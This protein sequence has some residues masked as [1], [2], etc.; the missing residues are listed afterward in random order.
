[1]YG[2]YLRQNQCDNDPAAGLRQF[3]GWEE[4]GEGSFGEDVRIVLVSAEFSKEIT[5]SVLWLNN[6]S[7]D[8]RCVRL[9]PH[10]LDGRLILDVQ[11]VI[12][13]PEAADYT[14]Q[15]KKKTEETRQAKPRESKISTYSVT[16]SGKTQ[17]GLSKNRL[18]L[19]VVRAAIAGGFTSAQMRVAFTAFRWISVPG[20]LSAEQFKEEA[21]KLERRS[22]GAY[23]FDHYF[24][25]DDELFRLDERTH[26]LS[27][28]WGTDTISIVD[29]LIEKLPP[30]TVSYL[31]EHTD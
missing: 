30:R 4:G 5:T 16:A 19:E 24:C 13:L 9:R 14:M 8:I 27:N 3:L 10:S 25:G 18:V 26:A 28:R 12:P 22:G 29:K 20:R 23:D 7:L 1:M 21:A 17:G 2:G 11:Q 31:R 6:R 15:L